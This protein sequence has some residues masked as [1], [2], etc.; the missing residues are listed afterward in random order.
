MGVVTLLSQLLQIGELA[1]T[2]IP[3]HQGGLHA[4]KAQDDHLALCR[5]EAGRA[6][7]ERREPGAGGDH[8]SGGGQ[9]L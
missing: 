1:L 7:G 4:V 9:S 6:A 3:F 2:D 5:L 8:R